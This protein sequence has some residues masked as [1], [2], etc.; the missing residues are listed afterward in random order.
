MIARMTRSKR[1]VPHDIIW[2]QTEHY[3]N[4][5]PVSNGIESSLNKG[6]QDRHLSQQNNLLNMETLLY[7]KMRQRFE[8][9][10]ISI[11]ALPLFQYSLDFPI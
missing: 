11:N 6:S 3:S 4:Q 1:S 2:A 9:H 10:G 8:S 7:A 5:R